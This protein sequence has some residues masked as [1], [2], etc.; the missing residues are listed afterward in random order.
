MSKLATPVDVIIPV[1]NAPDL[2]QRCIESVI[3]WLGQSVRYVHIQNDA[4]DEKTRLML[5]GLSY[6]QLR[7][8]HA[9]V[10]KG[11]GA[12]VNEAVA[13]SD[14]AYV[15]ILNS[16]TEITENLIPPLL[17]AM[18]GDVQ[19]AALI[20]PSDENFKKYDFGRYASQSGG[21]V[22]THRLHG[23]A[24]LMRRAVFEEVGGFD[25]IFGRGYYEDIDLGRRLDLR[26]WNFG[27]HPGT[28]IYHKGG[29][30]FG[31]GRSYKELMQG[32]RA[33]YF[34]RYPGAM[35]NI[36]L[37]SDGRLMKD[38]Y[39]GF[40]H[41]MD[42]VLRG[43]GSINWLSSGQ[44]GQLPCLQVRNDD[45]SLLAGLRLM[46]HDFWRRSDKR[47]SEVWITPGVPYFLGVLTAY[48]ARLRGIRVLSQE[49]ITLMRSPTPE[50]TASSRNTV[51]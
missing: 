16:D 1:Y 38:Y 21:Y 32:N 26:G 45:S 47:I 3:T 6:D 39:C 33:I 42:K 34:S 2:T 13:R 43:G 22:C 41:E 23:H 49:N 15:L 28:R 25:P 35:R 11:F 19:L 18:E 8:H 48:W 4:S 24:F 51:E 30:S 37:L 5:D 10:N 50:A 40:L 31:R 29:G 12:S 27:I 44:S 17:A 20:I 36:L 14:A 9:P 7:I 46:L